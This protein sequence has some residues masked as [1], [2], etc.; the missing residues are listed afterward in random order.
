M[1]RRY[2]RRRARSYKV[3]K[4]S[5]ETYTFNAVA[6]IDP[7][8]SDGPTQVSS[9]IISAGA[10]QGMRKAKNFT[11]QLVT[12][13]NTPIWFALV[14]KPEGV[15]LSRMQFGTPQAPQSIYEPNQNVI[16]QGIISTNC[17]QQTW[18][19]RLARNLNTGDSICL[20]F[21][22]PYTDAKNIQVCITLNYAIS[23]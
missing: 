7:S 3:Q 2:R 19:T 6:T 10:I 21:S 9:E 1:V 22:T 15:E 5:N 18:R 23:F 12:D 16:L 14:Y 17:Q 13:S 8:G 11:L 20:I 4:Y